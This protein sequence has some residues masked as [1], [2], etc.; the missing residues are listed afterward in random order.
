VIPAI[1][2]AIHHA[3]GIR[4]D[5]VPITPDKVLKALEEKRRGKPARVGPLKLPLLTFKEPIVVES[6]FGQ[7]ADAVVLR[8]FAS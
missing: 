2:N 4:I 3:L 5:E 6:A 1:A 7:P 8:P